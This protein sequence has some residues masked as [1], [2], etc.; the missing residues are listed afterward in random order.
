M[1]NEFENIL[2]RLIISLIGS[3][4]STDYKV[5]S[6][7][8]DKWKEKREIDLKKNKGIQFENRLIYF[9]D[10]YDIKTV[11]DKNWELF[12][13]I[14]KDKKRFDVFF[15]E[16]ENYRNTVAHG[17][18]LTLSQ[19]LL[20]EGILTDLKNLITI[21]HNKNEMKS[22]FFIEVTRINDNLGNIW[23]KSDSWEKPILRVG[24]EYELFIEAN[25]PKD[26]EIEYEIFTLN[27]FKIKQ[28]SNRF[29]FTV[30]NILVGKSTTLY[31]NAFTPS[32]DYKNSDGPL[33]NITVLPI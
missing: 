24:D 30:E 13:P 20:L 22:D 2:R 21:Y 14:L 28:K 33:L 11:I 6:D 16:I 1:I 19:N 3:K 25:D 10:F 18:N 9:S 31:I 7:R 5:P 27:G 26:R 12:L 29:N 15:K 32:S 8:I 4:D 23:S 17:R